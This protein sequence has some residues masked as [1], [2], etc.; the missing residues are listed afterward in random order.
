M[1]VGVTVFVLACGT[2][3]NETKSASEGFS[4]VVI[5]FMSVVVMVC[6]LVSVTVLISVVVDVFTTDIVNPLGP[7]LSRVDPPL[8]LKTVR[9]EELG[10]DDDVIVIVTVVG[11]TSVLVTV[12]VVVEVAFPEEI[13]DDDGVTVIVTVFEVTSG[14]VTVSIL[15]DV[16]VVITGTRIPVSIAV[17][18]K[19]P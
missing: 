18:V 13:V 19:L 17:V 3:E 5:V 9:I 7:L 6:L 11:A 15:V 14:L 10:Y 2:E 16:S 1:A 8:P 12:S 4:V